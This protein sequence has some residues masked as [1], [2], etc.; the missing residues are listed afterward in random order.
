MSL[1]IEPS[2]KLSIRDLDLLGKRLFLRVDFN[3]PIYAGKVL[4]D[5]RIR[6]S[7]PTIALAVKKNSRVIVASHLGRPK[8]RQ[9]AGCSLKPVADHLASLLKR[10]ILFVSDCIGA[11][12]RERVDMLRNGQVLLLEN[13]RFREGETRNDFRFA[14]KLA[15]LAQE[16]CNDA[17]GTAHRAHASTVG[18]P[19]ILG[20]GAAGLLMEKELGYLSRILFHPQHP[21]V[22]ILGGAK[23]SDKMEVIDN[24]LNFVDTILLGGN[25]AFTFL[26]AQGRPVGK[27]MVE[28]NKLDIARGAFKKARSQGVKLLLPTDAVIAERC[29]KGAATRVVQSDSIA[30]GWM[31]LDLGPQTIKEFKKAIAQAKT[32]IW[33]G[34]LGVFEIEEFA[35]GT[36]KIAS[37][38]A[39]SQALSV[40]GG[41]ESIL[42]LR[43][44]AVQNKITHLST[45]GGASLEFLAG[46]KL[47][48][49]EILTDR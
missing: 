22:A 35:Q 46:K 11:Q 13:L 43:K 48:G 26:K 31:G 9:R 41:G 21:I 18:I 40:V 32:I 38:V 39:K 45:G 44:A 10:E 15:G 28:N 20:R 36:L 33:N 34:P 12:V 8:G 2:A 5:T 23:V 30:D 1:S 47:P 16:Y 19:T 29:Q 6:A 49:L 17:F 3:V 27:S 37:A 24:F 14:H 7:L 42:A 25:M 4:D